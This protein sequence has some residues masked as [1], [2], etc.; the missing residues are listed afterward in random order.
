MRYA[1]N[2]GSDG[3]SAVLVD[4]YTGIGELSSVHELTRMFDYQHAEFLLKRSPLVTWDEPGR[5]T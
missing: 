4:N 1:A 3:Q 2:D 5:A